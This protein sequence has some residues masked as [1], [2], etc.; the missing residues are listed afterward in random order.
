MKIC[1]K[2]ILASLSDFSLCHLSVSYWSVVTR[3]R[4][5]L[6]RFWEWDRVFWLFGSKEDLIWIYTQVK[7][8]SRK[9]RGALQAHELPLHEKCLRG[10]NWK[11]VPHWDIAQAFSEMSG[12]GESWEHHKIILV[13]HVWCEWLGLSEKSRSWGWY[14]RT[15]PQIP[16]KFGPVAV[17]VCFRVGVDSPSRW[18]SIQELWHFWGRKSRS[19]CGLVFQIF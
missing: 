10:F 5:V 14:V 6:Q 12:D 2:A 16:I 18:L 1:S 9:A 15:T 13:S 17:E 8:P 19:K 11:T 7:T 3:A 4:I